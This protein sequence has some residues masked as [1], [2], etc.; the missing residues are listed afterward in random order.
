M[1]FQKNDQTLYISV[2]ELLSAAWFCYN[3]TTDDEEPLL[4]RLPA[5]QAEGFSPVSIEER[6][7]LNGIAVWDMTE[8]SLKRKA[9]EKML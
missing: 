3:G 2:E 6:L 8:K 4:Q 5:A 9:S 1:F 7:D